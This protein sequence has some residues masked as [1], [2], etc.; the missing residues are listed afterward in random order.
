VHRQCSKC[1]VGD[2]AFGGGSSERAEKVH[3]VF[4]LYSCEPVEGYASGVKAAASIDR[5][6]PVDGALIET[7]E[8]VDGAKVGGIGGCVAHTVVSVFEVIFTAASI[9][10]R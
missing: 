6:D 9:V 10:R 3:A 7:D 5:E 2:A 1:A 8:N 4:G